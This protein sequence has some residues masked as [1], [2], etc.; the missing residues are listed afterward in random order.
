MAL[1]KFGGV[2]PSIGAGS[3]VHPEA[4]L[5]G[6]VSIG[7]NCF[8]GPGARLRGDWG[9]ITVG[10]NCNIQDNCILHVQP[11]KALHVGCRCHIAHGAILHGAR[12]EE[13]VFV[14]MGCIV[15]DNALLKRQCALAAGALV[16][17]GKIIPEDML[18]LGCPVRELRPI[19]PALRKQL[20]W[21]LL[22]YMELPAKYLEQ[23]NQKSI[24]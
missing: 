18:A 16:S 14:G 24:L 9:Q 20:E 15:M 3:F 8:I 5:I 13:G 23:E 19:S 7:S 2:A 1:W 10:D 11:G 4:T 21:G 17:A 22:Q 12:L 6:N